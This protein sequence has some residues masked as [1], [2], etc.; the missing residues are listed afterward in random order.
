MFGRGVVEKR[1][2]LLGGSAVARHGNAC[3]IGKDFCVTMGLLF[4]EGLHLF[5]RSLKGRSRIG[6]LKLLDQR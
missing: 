5:L 6:N 4:K 3:S 1:R 2:E